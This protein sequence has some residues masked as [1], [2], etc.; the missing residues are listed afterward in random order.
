MVGVPTGDALG[1]FV[2]DLDM[3]KHGQPGG[4]ETLARLEANHGPLPATLEATTPSGGRHLY[5]KMPPGIDL[6]NSAGKIG[7]GVDV[8][9]NGGYVIA[10][11]SVTTDGRSYEWLCKQEPAEAPL[12]LLDLAIHG[13]K[14]ENAQQQPQG[15][16]GTTPYGAEALKNEC[17]KVILAHEGARNEALNKAAF[18]VGRLV[19]G[20]EINGAEAR[21]ELHHAAS[22]AGLPDVEA[23]RTIE[24]G[25]AAGKQ[26]PR[27]AIPK[28]KKTETPPPR[29]DLDHMRMG[30]F[31][32]TKP[33]PI[34]WLLRWNGK[35]SLPLGEVG[36]VVADGGTGKSWMLLQLAMAVGADLDTLD[37]L[38]EVSLRGKVLCLFGEDGES[39]L[40]YR[41][42][43]IFMEFTQR[44]RQ[45]LYWDHDPDRRARE[46]D[47]N[48]FIV[49]ATGDDW[50]LC[51]NEGGNLEE[52]PFFEELLAKAKSI[53]DLKLIILEP[54]SAIY[55]GDEN[56]ATEATFF[57]QLLYRLANETGAAVLV[58]HHTNKGSVAPGTPAKESLYQGAARGS[59][60]IPN[61]ARWQLSMAKCSK[62]DVKE[63]GGADDAFYIA[64]RVSK[65]NRGPE[66]DPFYLM[67][68][69][70]G[71]LRRH[72]PPA[73]KEDDQD[74]RVLA[75]V[76]AALREIE[77]QGG[78]ITV[79]TFCR[80]HAGRGEGYGEGALTRLVNEAS[81]DGTLAIKQEVYNSRGQVAPHLY[82]GREVEKCA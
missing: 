30:R 43:E 26:E 38:F 36:L 5:F 64:A 21:Q 40:H 27:S 70:G 22:R 33:P 10:P 63:I 34:Q 12:W 3:P 75:G 79:R 72:D 74:T 1:F 9:A 48:V 65:N 66:T 2:V 25:L 62:A 23:S 4:E 76:V 42:C 55:G 58:A 57:M 61:R 67:R 14:K 11:G 69:P 32:Q 15:F 80:N 20:R 45:G 77:A 50:R 19:A 7:P 47:E 44:V 46:L 28:Q 60:G 6:R 41:T 81:E 37:G 53:P 8:R 18:N 68:A 16:A 59:T 54:L 56:N 31:L 24:S 49:P 73:R 29:L 35:G 82:I 39:I 78:K 51:K 52:A 71:P 17:A 13:H